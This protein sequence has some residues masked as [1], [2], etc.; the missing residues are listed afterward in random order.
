MTALEFLARHGLAVYK[1]SDTCYTLHKLPFAVPGAPLAVLSYNAHFPTPEAAVEA[2]AKELGMTF[3]PP[4]ALMFSLP[5][6]LPFNAWKISVKAWL[7]ELQ[8]Q[9]PEAFAALTEYVKATPWPEQLSV[10]QTD[11][12]VKAVKSYMDLMK[13]DFPKEFTVI[14]DYAASIDPRPDLAQV[15]SPEQEIAVM[16]GEE[17]A[18]ENAYF[19]A[20]PGLPDAHRRTFAA[21][22]ARGWE[23]CK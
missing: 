1:V 8:D 3:T 5:K 2:A 10:T 4:H 22:F 15:L 11:E 23:A 18:S 7:T 6:N 19:D 14:A 9:Y 12:W 13:R 17:I 20:R 16:E 21:G